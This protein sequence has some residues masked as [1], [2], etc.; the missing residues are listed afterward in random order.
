MTPGRSVCAPPVR[1]EM[2]PCFSLRQR[3]RQAR[4]FL[5]VW[6]TAELLLSVVDAAE[7]L[8]VNLFWI[9]SEKT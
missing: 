8:Q 2:V 5:C 6:I 4:L 7:F 3:E 9:A 1:Q